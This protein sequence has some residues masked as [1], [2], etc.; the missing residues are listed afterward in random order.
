DSLT[1]MSQLLS[2]MGTAVR[3]QTAT[4][5]RGFITRGVSLE[6][7]VEEAVHHLSQLAR[8]DEISAG[9]NWTNSEVVRYLGGSEGRVSDG[10]IP[11]LVLLQREVTSDGDR[12]LQVG[13]EREIGRYVGLDKITRWVKSGAPLPK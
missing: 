13:P 8:F 4:S 2:D 1:G 3:R 10:R 7:A 5:G 12:F 6:P 11:T 9:G